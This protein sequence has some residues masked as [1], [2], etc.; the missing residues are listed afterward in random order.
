MN[1]AREHSE[2][3][4]V[5]Q[6]TPVARVGESLPKAMGA[7]EMRAAFGLSEPSFHRLQSL[8]EFKPFLLSRP[9][10]RKRYSG[11]KVQAFLNG[12]K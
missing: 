2:T 4:T 3:P 8:G 11:E 9:I 6:P 1:S 7:R 12:R 5:D 10:G